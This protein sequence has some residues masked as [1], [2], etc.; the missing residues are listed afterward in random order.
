MDKF[1]ISRKHMKKEMKIKDITK[2]SGQ[3]TVQKSGSCMRH[4]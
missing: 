2:I 1:L 3:M 4:L